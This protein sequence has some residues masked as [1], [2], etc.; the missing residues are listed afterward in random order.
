[1]QASSLSLE[2]NLE[3]VNHKKSQETLTGTIKV[4]TRPHCVEENPAAYRTRAKF[5]SPERSPR[6]KVWNVVF[7][8]TRAPHKETPVSTFLFRV[9][10]P[11]WDA[12][13]R[14]QARPALQGA[15]REMSGNGRVMSAPRGSRNSERSGSLSG[16]LV[17]GQFEHRR[18]IEWFLRWR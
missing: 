9:K 17:V 6:Y 4:F 7:S 2:W 3:P 12:V 16:R 13:P 14:F 5:G 10:S 1:M 11:E 18:D 15:C 8:V